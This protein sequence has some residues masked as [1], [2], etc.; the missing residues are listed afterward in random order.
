MREMIERVSQAIQL[1]PTKRVGDYWVTDLE[2]Q[3][4]AA[5]E[6]MREP[7]SGMI[8]QASYTDDGTN[9][10]R[11]IGPVIATEVWEAMIDLALENK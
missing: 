4:R 5:I 8:L 10:G 3:A 1:V 6:A 2:G 9:S 7:T 11:V